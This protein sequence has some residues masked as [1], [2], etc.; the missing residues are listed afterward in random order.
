MQDRYLKDLEG[1]PT[2]TSRL[3][4]LQEHTK[5]LI[6]N[7]TGKA[8]LKWDKTGVIVEVMPFDQ[9]IV[10][11]HGSNR[12]TRRNRKFLRAYVPALE[13]EELRVPYGQDTEMDREVDSA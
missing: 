1:P 3:P 2:T 4:P 7:Q 13:R 11:V 6:Q 8:P 5:V 10:K 12:L 9:Y